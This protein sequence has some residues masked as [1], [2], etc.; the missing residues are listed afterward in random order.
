MLG[1]DG[2]QLREWNGRSLCILTLRHS[3]L[4][5]LRLLYV[6]SFFPPS[7]SPKPNA[8]LRSARHGRGSQFEPNSGILL[9]Q[10]WGI[11][12]FPLGTRRL[13]APPVG[14]HY[15]KAQE[16]TPILLA[17]D[18]SN[19]F[20]VLYGRHAENAQRVIS[21]AADGIIVD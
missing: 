16:R 2:R 10:G 13:M 11:P 9:G 6:P 20:D 4:A 1:V 21:S 12:P 3:P 5:Y 15:T 19:A 17:C 14:L 7:S 18:Q 8:T